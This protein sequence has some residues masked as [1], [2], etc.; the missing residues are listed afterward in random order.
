[1]DINVNSDIYN[2]KLYKICTTIKKKILMT[3]I[4]EIRVNMNIIK[5]DSTCISI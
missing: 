1:M 2:E 4:L 3:I 5:T